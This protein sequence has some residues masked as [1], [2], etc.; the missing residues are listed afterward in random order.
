MKPLTHTEVHAPISHMKLAFEMAPYN[1]ENETLAEIILI[2][3]TF[4]C[5]FC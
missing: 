3:M 4:E 1:F 2:I 5:A